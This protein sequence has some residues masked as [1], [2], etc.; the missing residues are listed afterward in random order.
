[1]GVDI[2]QI[3]LLSPLMRGEFEVWKLQLRPWFAVP[4][5]G[6]KNHGYRISTM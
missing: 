5:S 4:E 2:L 3:G 6:T 1:M